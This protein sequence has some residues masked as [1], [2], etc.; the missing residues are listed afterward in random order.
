MTRSAANE[1]LRNQG[2]VIR[3]Q[4]SGIRSKESGVGGQQFKENASL[5][6]DPCLLTPDPCLL[7][8]ADCSLTPDD[9][10]RLERALEEYAAALKAGQAPDR[11]AFLT[12]HAEIA[13]LLEG[14]LDGLDLLRTAAVQLGTIL[15]AAE[16]EKRNGSEDI[17]GELGDFR[18]IREVGRG[19]MGIVYEAE[20]LSLHRRVALKVLPF[21]ATLDPRQLQ[22]FHNEARAAAS[23]H[24]AHIVP[25][26]AV[27]CER[28]VHYYAM[29]FID[30]QSLEA[31]LREQ[32]HAGRHGHSTFEK[33]VAPEVVVPGSTVVGAPGQ[34]ST[35]VSCQA[36]AHIRRVAELGIQAAEAL[37]HA[38]SLGVIHR[39]IKP[40][41]LLLDREGQLWIAD[42]GL[43]RSVAE[44]S[45]TRTGDL[46][47]TW[48]YMSPE[49]A[50]A[51]HGLVDHR[52]D[53]YSLGVT[54]YELLTLEPA[55]NGKDQREILH[56][57]ANTDLRS[58]R[59]LNRA[60][61]A[62]L[63]T[64][65]LKA[66]AKEANERYATAREL[67][68]DLQCFLDDRPIR[69]KR[70]NLWQRGRKWARR[71]RAVVVAACIALVFSL[72]VLAGAVG[73][74]LQERI[75]RQERQDA[76]VR[77]VLDTAEKHQ[78]HFRWR[79][80]L[81]A[82]EEALALINNEEASGQ[83]A[84]WASQRQEAQGLV[85]DAKLVLQLTELR[86]QLLD[87]YRK[88]DLGKSFADAFR[89]Y[90]LDLDKLTAEDAIDRL[91]R[92]PVPVR[93]EAAAFLDFW[94]WRDHAEGS[95]DN[96]RFRK[97]Y[98]IA[99]A[100]DPDPRCRELRAALRTQD[101]ATLRKL[102][103]AASEATP[104]SPVL[105]ARSLDLLCH[106][107]RQ[108]C[109]IETSL[110]TFRAALRQ[111]PED[112]RLHLGYA[113]SLHF[114]PSPPWV[115]IVRHCTAALALQPQSQTLR[116]L[117]ARAIT[118]LGRA[119][120]DWGD[121]D[122]AL[123]TLK[124]A[125]ST[126]EDAYVFRVTAEIYVRKGRLDD[127]L[128]QLDRASEFKGDELGV[129]LIR[130]NVLTYKH[131]FEK[132]IVEYHKAMEF[133][134]AN[135]VPHFNLANCFRD[136]EDLDRAI[137]EYE[138]AI[139]LRDHFEYH[140]GLGAI[141][142][143]KGDLQKAEK[144]YRLAL[145]LIPKSGISPNLAIAHFNLG[146]LLV[147]T[148]GV[149]D[150]ALATLRTAC[151]VQPDYVEARLVYAEALS[152]RGY[153]EDA[154]VELRHAF[155]FRPNNPA[156]LLLLGRVLCG[157]GRVDEG[158]KA[159]QSCL[160][161]NKG[162]ADAH[163]FLGL[164]LE[165]KGLEEK[166]E[167]EFRKAVD[168]EQDHGKAYVQLGRNLRDQGRFKE[169]L[170]VYQQGTRRASSEREA[171]ICRTCA[172]ECQNDLNREARLPQ[173][174]RDGL[175]RGDEKEYVNYAQLAFRKQLLGAAAKWYR[176]AFALD[177]ALADDLSKAHRYEA[178]A[179]AVKVAC[180]LSKDAESV[181]A[182]TRAQW[183]K[184][185]LAWLR[186]DQALHDQVLRSGSVADR[187]R[188]R[189]TLLELKRGSWLAC[190]R[191]PA[192]QL[193]LPDDELKSWIGFWNDVE[194]LL[195][196]T[197]TEA[198]AAGVKSPSLTLPGR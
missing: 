180:G 60:I 40:A 162:Y 156:A 2:T 65:V 163:F 35:H 139:K 85:A 118:D 19:G 89:G 126:A 82:G 10:P 120:A 155:R 179:A 170:E 73:W 109:D 32:R 96:D 49:Q 172:V 102:A 74:V 59:A 125:A 152:T 6:P 45:L 25:V 149:T 171:G 12:R 173:V 44:V 114:L 192:A 28:G 83:S 62:D 58:P 80:V 187:D 9:D 189:Q 68:E 97:F 164:A 71:H 47:G 64:I 81:P 30:G 46:L 160:A 197:N 90:G 29:Q 104:N 183:R 122:G 184:Q 144:E 7:T 165:M 145:R 159:L 11:Q 154:L 5:T 190:V 198:S 148:R 131:E 51:S 167:A 18:L 116:G 78:D 117:L 186:A 182:Q 135:P 1:P 15:P 142:E 105:P 4:E 94:A 157:A 188:V 101:R 77:E 55:I 111:Y 166:A 129:H 108:L 110:A 63:E 38:H 146:F 52:T 161:R 20:Q 193:K 185:A 123:E 88:G 91:S 119:Q 95:S 98:T 70:P 181:D 39:D 169:A 48:R 132:A 23:L 124:Q 31:L 92:R 106:A 37:E 42:F 17:V 158:I 33:T 113:Y 67:M 121:L 76:R 41:N 84:H 130:G 27:N 93:V 8:P 136:K 138:E 16:E 75:G 22:R 66:A 26:Y 107:L 72:A 87:T 21:A 56:Q 50:R 194:T 176:E 143:K 13:E 99:M 79:D 147:R 36:P 103:T 133:D 34:A 3:D 195:A 128:V 43:A 54:L 61:P 178:A 115:A 127:A 175:P 137:H 53:I 57:L 86:L 112:L 177:R 140:T 153:H 14:Y 196:R 168:F 134:R 141:L 151:L 150:E 174:L 191:D 24:H 69:A 100:I